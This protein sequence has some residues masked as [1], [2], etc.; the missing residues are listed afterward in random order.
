MLGCF[1]EV[2]PGILLEDFQ[3]VIYTLHQVEGEEGS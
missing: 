2:L 1:V 3:K